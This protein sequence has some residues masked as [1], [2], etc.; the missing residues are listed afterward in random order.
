MSLKVMDPA[1]HG[2]KPLE[3]QTKINLP[4]F[5]LIFSGILSQQWQLTKISAKAILQVLAVLGGI[6]ASELRTGVICLLFQQECSAAVKRYVAVKGRGGRG[7]PHQPGKRWHQLGPR[8][9]EDY[10]IWFGVC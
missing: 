7:Q 10:Q 5:Q 3:L 6:R 4:F 1:D 2:V 9:G 8:Q